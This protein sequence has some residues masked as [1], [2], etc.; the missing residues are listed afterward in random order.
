MSQSVFKI[1]GHYT[2]NDQLTYIERLFDSVDTAIDYIN[3]LDYMS[4]DIYEN[5]ELIQ[6]IKKI[7]S[8]SDV[9]A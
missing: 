6:T 8:D 7:E 5:T 2:N 4:I 1:T 3:S 9:V